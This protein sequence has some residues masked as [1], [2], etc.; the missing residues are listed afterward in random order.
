MARNTRW[1]RRKMCGDEKHQKRWYP[2]ETEARLALLSIRLTRQRAG[3][4]T[5]QAYRCI[6]C[7]GWHHGNARRR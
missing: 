6:Y 4:E 2:S 5:L 3:M 7:R 1:L